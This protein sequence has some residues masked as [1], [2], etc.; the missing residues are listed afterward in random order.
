MSASPCKV[1]FACVHNAGRSQIAAALFNALADPRKA[2]AKS[3]GTRP[4]D[5]PHPKVVEA[6]K[7][8]GI[9]IGDAV[10][11]FLTAEMA[12]SAPWLVTMGCGEQCPMVPGLER[13]G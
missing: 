10:P 5:R 9:D 3:A 13:A 8:I 6:L 2:I 12:G 7:E 11:R 1:I 4:A